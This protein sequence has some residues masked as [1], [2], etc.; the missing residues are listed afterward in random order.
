M[1]LQAN[2]AGII[3]LHSFTGNT[4]TQHL[5]S[6]S[7]YPSRWAKSNVILQDNV[8]Q[9]EYNWAC[10]CICEQHFYLFSPCFSEFDFLL[11]PSYVSSGFSFRE[12]LKVVPS[13]FSNVSVEVTARRRFQI[14]A[15]VLLPP[16]CGTLMARSEYSA[17]LLTGKKLLFSHSDID[18][19][20]QT[21]SLTPGTSRLRVYLLASGHL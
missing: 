21:L 12:V 8:T 17:G 4:V 5:T 7:F 16:V 19:T 2:K 1:H 18:P 13:A 9:Q 20:G 15:A 11:L 10:R 14:Y 3:T 6:V